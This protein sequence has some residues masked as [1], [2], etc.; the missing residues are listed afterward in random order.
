MHTALT[1][2]EIRQS[3]REICGTF[4]EGY[5]RELD[6]KREYPEAFVEAMTEAGHLGALIPGGYGGMGLGLAEASV[7]LEEINRSGGNAQPAHAQVYT[8]G[9]LLR[10]GCRGAE[11]EYLP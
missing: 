11:E 6:K 3:V 1:R 7:I 9:T 4:P 5:W 8:M 2:E 10:H